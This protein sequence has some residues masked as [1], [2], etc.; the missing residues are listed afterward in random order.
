MRISLLFTG[1]L[2]T[3]LL[4]AHPG[5]SQSMDKIKISVNFK[6][7]TLPEVFK[8]IETLTDFNFSYRQVDVVNLPTITYEKREVTLLKVLQGIL[9]GTHLIFVQK[10]DNIIIKKEGTAFDETFQSVLIP[11]TTIT[12]HGKVVDKEGRPLPSA[13]ITIKGTNKGSNTDETGNFELKKVPPHGILVITSLGYFSRTVA[14]DGRNEITLQLQEDKS[15]AVLQEVTVSTGYQVLPKE[16]ATGSFAFVDNQL[17]NKRVSIDIISKLEG[18]VPGLLFNRNVSSSQ[19]NTGGYNISI[20][21]RSTLVANDQPLVVVDNFPYDGDISAINPSDID[22]ISILKDAAAASI[23]GIRSGNG[24]IVITTKKG[25]IGQKLAVEVNANVT[26][27]DK[28]DLFY[29]P[30]WINST[31]FIDIEQQLYGMGYYQSDLT[32]ATH[33][34]VSPVVDLLDRQARGLISSSD[35]T[36]QI[37]ALRNKDFRKDETKYLYR[38]PV[39]QQYNVSFKGGGT[40]SDYFFSLGLDNNAATQVGNKNYRVTLNSFNNFYLFKGFTLSAGFNY[41]QN[42]ATNNSPLANLS[43]GAVKSST[44]YPYAQLADNNGNGL[45]LV[46][47]YAMSYTDTAGDGRLLN[48]KYNPLNELKYADNTQ[49]LVDNRLNLGIRYAFLN[50]F[51]AELKYQY[52]RTTTTNAKYQSDS[53]YY[54]RDL[55]NQFT[56][57]NAANPQHLVNPVPVGGI[58]NNALSTLNAHHLRAQLN[59]THAFSRRHSIAMLAGAEISQ[60]VTESSSYLSYGY[61]K[62]T[63]SVASVDL[64]DFFKTNPANQSRLIPNSGVGFGKLTDRYISYFANGT[65]SYKD[66]YLLSGSARIDKSNLFGVNTNQK[67]VPLYSM[68]IGWV[69]SKEAFYH[70]SWLPYAK[71]RATYGY[72]ANINK[73]IT[74]YTTALFVG[75]SSYFSALPYSIITNPANPELRWEKIGMLNVGLD[76]AAKKQVVSGSVEFYFKKGKDIIGQAPLAPSTGL[77]TLSGNFSNLRGNGMDISLNSINIQGKSFQWTSNLI[78]SHATDKVTKYD[79]ETSVSNYIIG[80]SGNS[81]SLYPLV[82]KPVNAIYSYQWMGLNATGAPQG[83]VN[84]KISTDYNGI[85]SGTTIDNMVYNGPSR[86]TA[87]GSLRNT[88]SVK[89]ISLSFNIL[90]KFNYYFRRSSINY[91]NLYA[92]WTDNRDYYKR[93]QKPGDENRTN[94]PALQLPPGD[95]NRETFYQFSSVLVDKADHIRLQDISISYDFNRARLLKTPFS[96]LQLY[97]YVNNIGILWRANKDKLDPDLYTGNLPIPRTYSFGIKANF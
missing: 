78:V 76:F 15:A 85:L 79:V 21:G 58:F 69:F 43:P 37:N 48:W 30:D 1:L 35:A 97:G 9:K 11:D 38:H 66:R 81:S 86:P 36:T 40:N 16:R 90:Y 87:F 95:N 20:R 23:W 74:A 93:W 91:L 54:T 84:G 32:S 26:T 5:M 28:P 10:G 60:D 63:G 70:L 52:E 68:G 67:S 89:G 4:K 94:V 65:Y 57:F 56:D 29:S 13:A 27:G 34:P 53:T 44:Y 59:Y 41:I 42:T 55:I 46:R 49:K 61:D 33:K 77:T 6:S 73:G 3:L 62:S 18:N 64:V 51:T 8:S 83:F 7:K 24:V 92:A 75:N 82:G 96:T 45:N 71:I 17:L 25:K 22:N 31:D 72:N 19:A 12:L 14:L 80:G 88:F 50:G 39:N 47:D 2:F